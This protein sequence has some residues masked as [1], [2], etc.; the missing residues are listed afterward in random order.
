M[1]NAASPQVTGIPPAALAFGFT[2][3]TFGGASQPLV[4]AQVGDTVTNQNLAQYKF[5]GFNSSNPTPPIQQGDGTILLPGND[6]ANA[7]AATAWVN[8]AKTNHWGGYAFGGGAYFEWV[9]KWTPFAGA[10]SGVPSCWLMDIEHQSSVVA[11]TYWPGQGT[12]QHW[13]EH[14]CM[15]YNTGLLN[16]HGNAYHDW[17]NDG[18]N[19]NQSSAFAAVT[20]NAS[21]SLFNKFGALW[22]PATIYARGIMAW[23]MNDVQLNAYTYTQLVN[24]NAF[25][26]PAVAGSSSMAIT[27]TRHLVPI[28]GNGNTD[29]HV[30][31][32]TVQS[33]SV[34]Q[35]SA[36]LNWFQ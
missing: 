35:N 29:G 27:D 19:H 13:C 6:A 28:I 2:T 10:I 3:Q 18:T 14:D 33:I 1:L 17:Y 24:N 31:D 36:T 20:A 9:M 30:P 12:T 4:Y 23:Y 26:P 34:W 5:F 32:V 7:G 8:A 22:V 11:L 16:K 25:A 21:Y 15:E